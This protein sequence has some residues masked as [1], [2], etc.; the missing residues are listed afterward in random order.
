MDEKQFKQLMNSF[1]ILKTS[2][3]TMNEKLEKIEENTGVFRT[4]F[5]RMAG[6]LDTLIEKVGI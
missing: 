6:L 4:Y 1:K 2:L 5:G 3:D